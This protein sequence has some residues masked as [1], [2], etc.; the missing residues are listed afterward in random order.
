M[1][2]AADGH[3]DILISIT[4]TVVAL[5]ATPTPSREIFAWNVKRRSRLVLLMLGTTEVFRT[6]AKLG[7]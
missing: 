4:T 2:T 1:V 3:F 6:D 7:C 5:M